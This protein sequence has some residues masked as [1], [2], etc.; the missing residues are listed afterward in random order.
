MITEI[1]QSDAMLFA[2]AMLGI[3]VTS[4]AIV[5]DYL[6]REQPARLTALPEPLAERDIAA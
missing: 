6:P 3:G 2:I 5:R 4:V 1:L